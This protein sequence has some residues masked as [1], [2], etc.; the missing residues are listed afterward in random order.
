MFHV[1]RLC[2]T[3]SGG[4]NGGAFAGARRGS[5]NEGVWCCGPKKVCEKVGRASRPS[6]GRSP[7]QGLCLNDAM[8]GGTPVPPQGTSHTRSKTAV[9]HGPAAES[10]AR[11]GG[12][13]AGAGVPRAVARPRRRPPMAQRRETPSPT[14]RAHAPISPPPVPRRLETTPPGHSALSTSNVWGTSSACRSL[15][16]IT[17]SG[18]IVTGYDCVIAGRAHSPHRVLT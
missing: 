2:A 18:L 11:R 3:A 8:T 1:K 6:F 9:A 5:N 13:I 17:A 7:K 14:P 10:V 4:R 16:M 12:G 15:V